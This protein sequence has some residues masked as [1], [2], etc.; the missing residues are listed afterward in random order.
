MTK[1]QP[2]LNG[3]QVKLKLVTQDQLELIRQWRNDPAISQFM[4]SQNVISKEQQLAW[5]K[6]VSSDVSQQHFVIFYKD[7]AIGVANIKAYYHNEPLVQARMIE[8][9]LYIADLRYR[10]NILAFSPSLLLLD[11]CF[12]VLCTPNVIAVVKAE[13][14]AALHYNQKLGY[15]ISE[16]DELIELT[17][18]K[19]D[20]ELKVQ[21]LKALLN[22]PMTSRVSNNKEK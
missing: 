5:F 7:Q 19:V 11:Y 12:H 16:Q 2:E 14:Q 10:S 13:N 18:N 15:Q 9:G 22:R 6:K 3:Y 20:Y 21:S 17:L 1:L 4:L 8:P